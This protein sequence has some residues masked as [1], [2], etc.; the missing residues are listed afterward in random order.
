MSS[1]QFCRFC[2]LSKPSSKLCDLTSH[3]EYLEDVKKILNLL[4]ITIVNFG[5]PLLPMSI[6]SDCYNNLK[7]CALVFERIKDSQKVLSD[8]FSENEGTLDIFTSNSSSNFNRLEI[9][10]VRETVESLL[11]LPLQGGIQHF[12]AHYIQYVER[13]QPA[14]NEDLA[15]QT[16]KPE[17]TEEAH[18]DTPAQQIQEP[19]LPE[20][21]Q[22]PDTPAP[23][24]QMPA[25]LIQQQQNEPEHED[26]EAQQSQM[27]ALGQNEQMP[28]HGQTQAQQSQMPSFKTQQQK[29]VHGHTQAQQ[30][31]MP[32]YSQQL[33][34]TVLAIQT[35]STHQSQNPVLAQRLQMPVLAQ[36]PQMQMASHALKRG[37]AQ[38]QM[39]GLT[40][41]PRLSTSE[42][43]P[44]KTAMFQ[45]PSYSG[46]PQQCLKPAAVVQERPKTGMTLRSHNVRLVQSQYSGMTLQSA[47]KPVQPVQSGIAQQ[48]TVAPPISTWVTYPKKC[49]R[50][51]VSFNSFLS[52]KG[53]Q[54]SAHGV[55]HGFQCADCLIMDPSFQTYLRH[56]LEHRPEL[57]GFCPVCFTKMTDENH[58]RTHSELFANEIQFAVPNTV[59]SIRLNIEG[60][61]TRK[62]DVRD[63]S[64]FFGGVKTERRLEAWCCPFCRQKCADQVA[65]RMHLK[66]FHS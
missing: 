21:A 53:H 46:T 64:R 37:W 61:K 29:P 62:I 15:Q 30:A 66:N 43:V 5:E 57:S 58:V 35:K 26:I 25:Q 31:Q 44:Q 40:V 55:F 36:Q 52:L 28:V 1:T 48:Y 16:E 51:G 18:D 41:Q 11:K 6:C 39:T 47:E 19:G 9:K 4:G 63:K 45:H 50:C 7:C 65:M 42:G 60:A 49:D 17:L 32:V 14:E 2:A 54:Q 56:V 59:Q 10:E 34:I 12:A 23:Q 38:S 13:M 8:L 22:T 33:Q 27:A 20:L 3:I 24:S